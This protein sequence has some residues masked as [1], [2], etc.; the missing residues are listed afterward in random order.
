MKNKMIASN[1]KYWFFKKN[2]GV[3]N[4]SCRGFCNK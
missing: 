4:T 1:E 2:T 3:V